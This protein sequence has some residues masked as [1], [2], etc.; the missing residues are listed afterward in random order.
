MANPDYPDKWELFIND[1]FPKSLN[2]TQDKHWI[3]RHRRKRR[4]SDIVE[5]HCL[6]AG[7]IPKFDGPVKLKIARLWGKGQRKLDRV[8]L[9]GAVKALEDVLR[10]RKKSGKGFQGSLGIIL[11]DDEDHCHLTV[12]QQRNKLGPNKDWESTLITIRGKRV[13]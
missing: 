5:A 3:H 13:S 11:D 6:A 7:G 1:F 9:W 12:S 10:V 8:N 2:R 4:I